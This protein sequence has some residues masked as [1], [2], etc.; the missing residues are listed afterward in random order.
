MFDVTPDELSVWLESPARSNA[1]FRLLREG[2][3][4]ATAKTLGLGT[5][6]K[7]SAMA[8]PGVT[9]TSAAL[10]ADGTEKLCLKLDD[11]HSV[12]LVLIPTRT[13]TTVCVSSQVGCARACGFCRTGMLGLIRNLRPSEIVAQVFLGIE[14]ARMRRLPRVR[15]LVFMGMGEPLDNPRAV[16][17]ALDIVVP[18]R[19]FALGPRHVTVSTVGP[20]PAAIRSAGDL[21]AYLAWSLH[22]ADETTR[23]RMVATQRYSPEALRDAFADVFS[24][25]RAPFF[26]EVALIKGLNDSKEAA[27]RLV[28]LFRGF[29]S[30]VRFNLLPM[31]PVPNT[32]WEGSSASSVRRFWLTLRAAGFITIVRRARGQSSYAAC[33]QLAG[34]GDAASRPIA[35]R[36][37]SD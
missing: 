23:K 14:R 26:V 37:V 34:L 30:E 1:V 18:N 24:E 35:P 5:R 17:R 31:N 28:E 9:V 29:P 20:S 6:E 13:R 8:A 15:N 16:R 32:S 22:A 12:E 36:S 10:S 21:P 4:P 2:E 7:L 3:H 11:G 25:R 33:G 19:G 27:S